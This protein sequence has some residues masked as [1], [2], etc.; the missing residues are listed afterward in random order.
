MKRACVDHGGDV[1][2]ECADG[3]EETDGAETMEK[4]IERMLKDHQRWLDD[5]TKGKRACLR[6]RRLFRTD[7]LRGANLRKADGRGTSLAGID[8]TG[9]DLREAD[10]SGAYLGGA[11]LSHVRLSGADLGDAYLGCATLHRAN[12]EVANLRAAN[13]SWADLRFARLDNATL[14]HATLNCANLRFAILNSADMRWASV[15]GANL[16][17]AS[18]HFANLDDADLAEA[19]L[20]G[21]Y[22]VSSHLCDAGYWRIEPPRVSGDRHSA[23]ALSP[24]MVTIG[25]STLTVEEWLGTRGAELAQED[26]D[27]P[28]FQVIRHWLL[29]LQAMDTTDK[30]QATPV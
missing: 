28:D 25:C 5:P 18:L 16:Y 19:N 10:M 9:A 23:L 30:W 29:A 6:D 26:G 17:R 3:P 27:H 24:T 13:L 12:L 2:G 20:C 15:R 21:A 11:N 8:V 14:I 7:V 4:S 22:M 1:I